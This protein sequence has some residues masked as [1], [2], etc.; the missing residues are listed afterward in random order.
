MC[1]FQ[2]YS[3]GQD[4]GPLG[5]TDDPLASMR[6]GLDPEETYALEGGPTPTTSSGPVTHRR[7]P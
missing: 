2:W 4:G 3:E 6:P 5:R 1:L 7:Y